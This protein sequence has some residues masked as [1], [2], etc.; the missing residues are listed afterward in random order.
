MPTTS[1][2]RS[3]VAPSEPQT[4]MG[5]VIIRFSHVKKRFGPKIVFSDLS[6]ELRRGETTAI[7]GASGSGKS[8][9]LKMLIGLIPKDSGTI[10]FEDDGLAGYVPDAKRIASGEAVLG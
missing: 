6:I 9:L 1:N 8:V 7:L 10:E 2:L 5:E 3:S 4:P